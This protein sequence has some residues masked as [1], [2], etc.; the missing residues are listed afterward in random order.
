MR[1]RLVVEMN[2][3]IE[4]IERAL[5][6]YPG[7]LGRGVLLSTCLFLIISANVIGK[8]ARDALFLTHFAAVQLPYADIASGVLVGFVVV[9]YFRV[10]RHISLGNL[11]VASPLFF[12]ATCVLFWALAHYSGSTWTYPAFYIWVVM[13]GVLAP[14]QVWT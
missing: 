12:G 14:T 8:V 6:L 9:L 11:L 10:G 7:D 4:W 2:R 5:N 3:W 1:P 13:L